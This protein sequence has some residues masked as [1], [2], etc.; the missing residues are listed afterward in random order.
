MNMLNKYSFF[1]IKSTKTFIMTLTELQSKIANAKAL[2]FGNIFNESIELFKKSWLQ[3][4]LMQLFVMILMI[5]FI[6]I[7]Y[8]PFFIAVAS[9]A[10]NGQ[11]DPQA[12]STFMAGFSLIYI[13]LFIIGILA[14]S[15][16]SMA[17]NAGLFRILR[18]LDAGKTVK[19]SD[20]FYFLKG[21]YIGKLLLIM[22][23]TVLIAIPSALLCYIPLIY[24]MVPMS[25]FA[26]VFAFNP[27]FNVGDIVSTSFRLG[28][29]KWGIA[30]CLI[31]VSSILAS[32]VGML[33][34][35]IGTLITAPFMYHP[36]YFIYKHVIGFENNSE[37]DEIGTSI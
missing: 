13:I 2:D 35:G 22:L 32:L 36:I 1:G 18:D 20:L 8:V 10:E 30:F 11:V 6:F 29:K 5:P 15:V 31:L 34:C 25:F 3:G 33:L 12:F 28:T 26:V 7:I 21:K 14:I 9:Q 17:L 23:V 27:D 24:T 16:I 37:I 4:F 19:T